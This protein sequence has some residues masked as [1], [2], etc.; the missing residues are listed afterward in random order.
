MHNAEEFLCRYDGPCD[1]KQPGNGFARS[2]NRGDH[3]KRVH[4]IFQENTRS[5]GRPKAGSSETSNA[6]SSVRRNSVHRKLSHRDG[7]YASDESSTS[8]IGAAFPTSPKP[9]LQKQP[10]PVNA[11]LT[12]PSMDYMVLAGG[13]NVGSSFNY[14]MQNQAQINPGFPGTKRTRFSKTTRGAGQTSKKRP[15]HHR[16]WVEH[17]RE[18]RN[19]VSNL[20]D[21]PNDSSLILLQ[22]IS[23]ET[24]ELQRLHDNLR[25]MDD[26]DLRPLP[27]HSISW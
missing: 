1:R 8:T 15:D 16:Y 25:H 19:L 21:T 17:T 14:M 23:Q 24:Y 10:A 3:E 12:D 22:S 5:K 13:T 26:H 2:F 9:R 6:H 11:P 18:L 20:P 4:H 7:N 27:T